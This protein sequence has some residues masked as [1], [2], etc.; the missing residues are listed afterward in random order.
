LFLLL[1]NQVLFL[2]ERTT[3]VEIERSLRKRRSSNRHSV[4]FSS[5]G[6]PKALHYYSGYGA[7]TKKDL[8]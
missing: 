2:S 1:E 8:A 5:R 3:G 4:A 7:L 6:G